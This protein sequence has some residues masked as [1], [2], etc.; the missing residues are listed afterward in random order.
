MN[1]ADP[2]FA[3]RILWSDEAIFKVNGRVKRYNC[4][5][6]SDSYPHEILKKEVNSPGAMVWAGVEVQGVI[7]PYFFDKSVNSAS[8]LQLLNKLRV[9]LEGDHNLKDAIS[10]CNKIVHQPI[11]T[12]MSV[13]FSILISQ[14][15]SEEVYCLSVK[16]TRS[17]NNR[18]FCIGCN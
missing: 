15:G 17:Y 5:Y 9:T 3:K 6:W 14:I 7:D 13:H 12:S 18:F 10:F 8:Y 16:V 4:V 2:N 11:A 1:E